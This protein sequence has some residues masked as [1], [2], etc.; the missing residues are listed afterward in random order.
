MSDL[1]VRRPKKANIKGWRSMLRHYK[2]RGEK[3]KARGGP[4]EA[5]GMQK[6]R[7]KARARCPVPLQRRV[8]GTYFLLGE[9]GDRV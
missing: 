1:K 4:V 2:G 3:S 5:F 6:A 8:C 9:R 7:L